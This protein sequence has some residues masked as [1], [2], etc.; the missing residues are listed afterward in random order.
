MIYSG[1]P[2]WVVLHILHGSTFISNQ[3]RPQF[4]LSDQDLALELQ[5]MTDHFTHALF[6]EPPGDAK[7]DVTGAVPAALAPV[8]ALTSAGQ[9]RSDPTPGSAVPALQ[10][11]G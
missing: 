9:R 8:P 4:L 1:Y 10:G 2:P 11:L 3:V 7:P 5:R 6:A